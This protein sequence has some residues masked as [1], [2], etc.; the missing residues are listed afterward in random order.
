MK[1]VLN[2]LYELLEL[3]KKVDFL[4]PLALRLYLV[5]IF[6]MAGT[7]KWGSFDSTVEWFGNADWGLGL[8]FPLV[9]AF[10]ATWTEI[11]G[12]ISLLLGIGLRWIAGPL[13]FTMI[14][15][16]TTVH[17]EHGWQAI[18]DPGGSFS[19]ERVM[20]SA[21][22]LSTAKSI[23][24]ENGNYSWL[25]SSGSIVVLNNGI[26]FA[27]TYLI[28]LLSLL[29]TGAGRFVSFDYWFKRRYIDQS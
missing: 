22:K 2:K 19:N 17:A 10:L 13:I 24:K 25:T 26:E 7:K 9:L 14:I 21:E 12:A 6:W 15:A 4:A 29:F 3:T 20:E 28:M 1:A 18:A 16:M 5:P 8:P 27:A 23:L 11:L